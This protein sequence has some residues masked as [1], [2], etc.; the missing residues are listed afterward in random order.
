M[1][2]GLQLNVFKMFSFL[3]EVSFFFFSLPAALCQKEE[4]EGAH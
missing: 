2:S 1:A 3:E 4:E